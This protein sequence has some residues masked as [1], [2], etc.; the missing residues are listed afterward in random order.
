MNSG[1]ASFVTTHGAH[2][3]NFSKTPKRMRVCNRQISTSTRS[4]VRCVATKLLVV[5]LQE[6]LQTSPVEQ[7]RSFSERV[8]VDRNASKDVTFVLYTSK[9][10]YEASMQSIK[11]CELIE[12]DAL[13]AMDGS[14]L[15]QRRYF[16]PDPH[17]EKN[18]R[19]EWEPKPIIWVVRQ[20]FG[21]DLEFEETNEE[22]ELKFRCK[23][24]VDRRDTCENISKKM[25][26]MGIKVRVSEGLES[27]F[28]VI[29]PA[30]GSASGVVAFCQMMLGIKEDSTYIFG[31]DKLVDDC[32]RG[33]GNI[34][35]CGSNSAE[36]WKDFGGRVYVSKELGAGALL[37]GVMHHAVF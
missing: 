35:L 6:L 13:S 31:D 23:E 27:N 29:I 1:K 28:I 36:R 17:W 19:K 8:E 15:Y 4:T 12:P 7:L 10:G 14:E 18:I 22:F 33:K 2:S 5:D 9:S 25:E 37:D 21:K 26:E 11:D 16:T 30:G 20:F 34:G 3:F 32:V 24:G